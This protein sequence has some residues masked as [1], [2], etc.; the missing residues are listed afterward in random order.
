M[1]FIKIDNGYRPLKINSI[2]TKAN[3]ASES[4]IIPDGVSIIPVEW[5]GKRIMQQV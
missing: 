4:G 5:N 2:G 3:G 1:T